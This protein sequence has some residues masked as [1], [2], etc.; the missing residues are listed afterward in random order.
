[1]KNQNK[2]IIQNNIND[3]GKDQDQE[4]GAAVPNGSHGIGAKIEKER[5]GHAPENN[6]YIGKGGVKNFRRSLKKNKKRPGGKN[7]HGHQDPADKNTQDYA[8]G[9]TA[10]YPLVIPRAKTL[11]SDN[12]SSH[13][14]IYQKAHNEEIDASGAAYRRQSPYADGA[15]Y[16]KGVGHI[17]KLLEKIPNEER[18]GKGKYQQGGITHGEIF[19]HF[20]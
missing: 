12:G 20:R 9:E 13:G 1:M 6:Y 7:A 4:G 3:A 15:A 5:G 10:P 18:N 16:D 19:C 11:G 14:K 8:G 17:V 2:H